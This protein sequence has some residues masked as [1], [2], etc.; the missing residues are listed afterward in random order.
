MSTLADIERDIAKIDDRIAAEVTK[1]PR[2]EG[3]AEARARTRI[4]DGLSQQR[5]LLKTRQANLRAGLP[6]NHGVEPPPDFLKIARAE[7]LSA[8]KRIAEAVAET[9]GPELRKIAARI[10]ELEQQ[11]KAAQATQWRGVWQ[12]Q[13]DY[14]TG[15]F[16][17]FKGALWHAETDSTGVQPGTAPGVW[18]LAVKSGSDGKGATLA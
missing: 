8:E 5:D 9:V 13:I 12:R 17:T 18:T 2:Y 15:C 10:E 14:A 6:E 16:V 1:Q 4:M 7:I 3:P 11:L